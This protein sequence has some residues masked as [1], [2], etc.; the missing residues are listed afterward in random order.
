VNCGAITAELGATTPARLD[1]F[2]HWALGRKEG[3]VRGRGCMVLFV[4]R[5][6]RS[7]EAVGVLGEP[8]SKAGSPAGAPKCPAAF[9]R[10]LTPHERT[11]TRRG[12]RC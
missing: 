3:W 12:G 4:I 1:T 9:A 7:Q 11:L 2:C 6:G 8:I 5:A 10:P